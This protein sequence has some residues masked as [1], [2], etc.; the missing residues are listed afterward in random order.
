MQSSSAKVPRT[1]GGSNNY[2]ARA[3]FDYGSPQSA[4]STVN[5]LPASGGP[6]AEV[7]ERA[8]PGG[9]WPAID[10]LMSGS[11]VTSVTDAAASGKPSRRQRT[12][13]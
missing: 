1:A 5:A 13:G 12:Q 6:G 4:D 10:V 11:L 9:E 3:V 2:H 8:A 7:W